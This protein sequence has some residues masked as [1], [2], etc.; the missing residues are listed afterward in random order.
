[1]VYHSAI[2]LDTAGAYTTE[3]EDREEC[4]LSRDFK[5]ASP[6]TTHQ[7]SV[8]GISIAD[9]LDANVDEVEAHA[10]RIRNRIDELIEKLAC[11][12]RYIGFH[13]V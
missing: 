6:P 10:K 1:M 7:R 11:A 2:L 3:D 9:L 8:G 12:F 13:E 5:K 4:S